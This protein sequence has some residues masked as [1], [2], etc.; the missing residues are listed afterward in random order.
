MTDTPTSVS[1]SKTL[2]AVA[3]PVLGIPRDARVCVRTH[4]RHG[5]VKLS[6]HA[7]QGR[8]RTNFFE[9]SYASGPVVMLNQVRKPVPQHDALRWPIRIFNAAV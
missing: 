2:A 8:R 7:A 1:L 5:R 9:L 4:E 3:G 6:A